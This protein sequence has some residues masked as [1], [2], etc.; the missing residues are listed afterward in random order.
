VK[1]VDP[2]TGRLTLAGNVRLQITLFSEIDESGD[3]DTLA[4]VKAA[5]EA[6]TPV[7]CD[8]DGFVEGGVVVV[9]RIRFVKATRKAAPTG[10][11]A[12]AARAAAGRTT[13]RRRSSTVTS[14]RSTWPTSR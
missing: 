10:L 6:G 2:S 4:E 8:M 12:P 7:L 9:V 13:T 14:R 1:A 5:L 3:F 11:A